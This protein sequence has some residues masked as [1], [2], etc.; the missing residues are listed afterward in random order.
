MI[1][2]SIDTRDLSAEFQLSQREVDDML[3]FVVDEVTAQFARNWDV[4]AKKELKSTRELYR[5]AIQVEKRDKFT[6]VVYLNPAVWIANALE[7]GASEFDMKFGFLSSNKVKYTKKGKPYL[8]IG[9][10]FAI[11]TSIGENNAFSGVMP[12]IIHK[13]AKSLQGNARLTMSDI[14][15]KYHIPQSATLRRKLKSGAMTSIPKGTVMTSIYE[16]LGRNKGG[17][18]VMFRRVSTNSDADRWIHP[19]FE[20]RN[21]ADKALQSTDVPHLVDVA[22]DNYLVHLG[23]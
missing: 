18:Y 7:M 21:L 6:G 15:E 3:E 12:T 19:G 14:P 16:G 1:N 23:F 10:R 20:P 13:K 22:I 2:L 9:F 4:Q 11:P 8:T 17:G 5:Q